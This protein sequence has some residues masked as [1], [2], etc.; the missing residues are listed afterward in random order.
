M[1]EEIPE[2][3]DEVTYKDLAKVYTSKPDFYSNLK[4]N[5]IHNKIM[6]S[7]ENFQDE[8]DIGKAK[9]C[10]SISAGSY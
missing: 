8:D 1:Y 3:D 4:T 2:G 5:S 9:H 10:N 6:E 7:V